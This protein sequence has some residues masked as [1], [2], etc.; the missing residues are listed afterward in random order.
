[1]E[2]K[3]YFDGDDVE[4]RDGTTNCEPMEPIE[5]YF[6]YGCEEHVCDN[7]TLNLALIGQHSPEEHLEE[8]DE[9]DWE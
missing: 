1:M 2:N 6:C 8:E 7:H 3:C 5:D 9:E 4:G